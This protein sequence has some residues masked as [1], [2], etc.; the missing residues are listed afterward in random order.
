MPTPD[1]LTQLASEYFERTLGVT[2]DALLAPIDGAG[3]TGAWIRNTATYQRIVKARRHDDASIPLG[4]WEYDLKRADWPAVGR[5]TARAL[6]HESK[7]LELVT[8]LLEARIQQDGFDGIAPCVL[9]MRQLLERYWETLYPQGDADGYAHRANQI[10][11]VDAKLLS[12]LRLVPLTATTG[13]QDYNWADWE[14]AHRNEQVR[15]GAGANGGEPPEGATMAAFQGAVNATP[16]DSY[17]RLGETLTGALRA[18]GELGHVMDE[19]FGDEAPGLGNMTELLQ[20]ILSLADSELR[21][22]GVAPPEPAAV[23]AEGTPMLETPAGV[24]ADAPVAAAQVAAAATGA[25]RDRA[26]AYRRLAQLSDYLME[27][28]PHSPVPYL[29]RR[30]TEWGKLSAVELYRELFMQPNA[31]SIFEIMG[32]Q[33]GRTDNDS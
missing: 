25:I 28:E 10:G 1:A 32:L 9:L 2:L 16:V 24:R 3:A 8:W 21:K 23:E 27:V 20:Q 6:C 14:Q 26:D 12:T 29:V 17:R 19:K 31:L 11:W 13:Q 33:L 5:E 30:A 15:A 4:S 18:I 7:D 22:R